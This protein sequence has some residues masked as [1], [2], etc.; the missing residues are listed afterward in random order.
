MSLSF[1]DQVIEVDYESGFTAAEDGTSYDAWKSLHLTS[2]F[3]QDHL[4]LSYDL[5]HLEDYALA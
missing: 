4:L 3:L 1:L 2:E 5:I